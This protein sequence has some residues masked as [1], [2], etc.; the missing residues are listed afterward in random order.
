MLYKQKFFCGIIACCSIFINAASANRG[1][2][3]F[4]R[5]DAISSDIRARAT[6]QNISQSVID[7]AL[8]SAVFIPNIISILLVL[9]T[10]RELQLQ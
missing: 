3:D 6:N 8:K 9:R 7:D 1:S 10:V 5:W 4:E 2:F